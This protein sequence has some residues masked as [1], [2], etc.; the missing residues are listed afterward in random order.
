MTSPPQ[1]APSADAAMDAMGTSQTG[2]PQGFIPRP[3]TPPADAFE[4]GALPCS[5]VL[6]GLV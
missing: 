5:M 2:W 3:T 1:S 6:W 4:E